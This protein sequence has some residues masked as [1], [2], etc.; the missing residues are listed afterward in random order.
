MPTISLESVCFI[1]VKARE[2]GAKVA[3]PDDDPASNASDDGAAAILAD[4]D[5]DPTYQELRSAIEALDEGG[6]AELVALLWVGRGDFDASEWDE[7]LEEARAHRTAP[8]A[9]YLIGTPLL[10][11]CIEEGLAAFGLSCLDE[12]RGHL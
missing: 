5:D 8:T 9:D 3:P 11:D 12:E 4:Y 1:V 6:R 2:F 10:A 7:A